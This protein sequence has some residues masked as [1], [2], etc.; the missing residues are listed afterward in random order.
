MKNF[1]KLIS[2]QFE[3]EVD[4]TENS[5]LS[6]IESFDSLTSFM[7]IDVIKE[8]YQIE[9]DQNDVKNLTVSEI[10]NKLK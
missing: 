2:D 1:I 7:I 8:T 5:K 6:D 4:L 10:Y 3:E 9:I